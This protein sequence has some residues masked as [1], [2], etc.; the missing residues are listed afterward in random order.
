LSTPFFG[1]TTGWEK[2]VA[3]A[4]GG[5]AAA[6]REVVSM[7]TLLIANS[8]I[9]RAGNVAGKLSFFAKIVIADFPFA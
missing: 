9:L 6:A 2:S 5:T 8:G 4:A 3:G 7:G 1:R